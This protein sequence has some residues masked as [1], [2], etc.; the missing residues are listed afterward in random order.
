MLAQGV[1]LLCL[2]DG[3]VTAD[4]TT[5]LRGC[6]GIP[7]ARILHQLFSEADLHVKRPLLYLDFNQN[8]N[9]L[10]DCSKIRQYQIL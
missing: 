8:V 1:W 7:Y 5:W 6:L 2:G 10:T 4:F 9:V 3:L